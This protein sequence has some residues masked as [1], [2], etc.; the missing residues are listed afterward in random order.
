MNR[1]SFFFF[2]FFNSKTLHRMLHLSLFLFR[3]IELEFCFTILCIMDR[4]L[5][6]KEN[7]STCRM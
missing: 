6:N 7:E 3:Q 1:F 5:E 4:L 2:F